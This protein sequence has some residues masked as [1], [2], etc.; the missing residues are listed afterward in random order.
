MQNRPTPG[1]KAPRLQLRRVKRGGAVEPWGLQDRHPKSHTM[2]V[3]YRGHHSEICRRQLRELDSMYDRFA[4]KGV[5]V[6]AVSMDHAELARTTIEEDDLRKIPVGHGL[7]HDEAVSWGLFLS[8]AIKDSEPEE[9]CEPA[10]Y[11]ID[12]DGYVYAAWIQSLEFAR[13]RFEDV[14]EGIEFIHREHYPP[15]GVAA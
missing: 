3:F 6:M 14:L 13:P 8:T 4:E 11:L 1:R 2:V 10:T 15:R 5:E 7:T 12:Q 9:F